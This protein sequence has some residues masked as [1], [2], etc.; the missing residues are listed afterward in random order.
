MGDDDDEVWIY[1]DFF[2]LLS[3]SLVEVH[4]IMGGYCE[5]TRV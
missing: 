2:H 1:R 3:L 5:R 4:V